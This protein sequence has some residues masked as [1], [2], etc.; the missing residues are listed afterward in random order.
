MSTSR[1]ELLKLGAGTAALWATGLK[2][3]AARVAAGEK[4]I[5]LGLQL[6]SVRQ[7]A[8]KDLPA[9][10]QAVAEMGYQ[11]VEFAGYHG[12]SAE[13]LKK[14]LDGNGLRCCGTHTHLGT[15][16][17]DEL[18]RTVEFHQTIGN[19][20]LIVPGMPHNM[21]NS[22]EAIKK[23]AALFNEIAEKLKPEGMLTGYHAHGGDF[24]KI[25]DET[26]WDLLFLN[27]R[28]D[29]V[30]QL[31]VGNCLGGGGDPYAVLKRFPGRSKTVH[32]K[33]HGGKAGAAI[34]EG[35]VDWKRIFD[36]CETVG[37]TEWYIAEQ[38][39]YDTTP[40]ESVKRCIENLRKMGV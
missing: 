20:Y 27:T 10:L 6:Y 21:R 19:K 17:G 33:E 38:E 36:L 30:M 12:H 18:K 25:G 22:L 26:A 24:T 40:L 5:P 29:V 15:L 35:D 13:E 2:P 31:D 37:G 1:R 39:S 9:V 28:P 32:L 4:K 7:D 16:Q 3:L 14:L 34:G 11:G 8:A 23:T